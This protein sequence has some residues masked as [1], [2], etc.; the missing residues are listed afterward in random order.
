MTLSH[1]SP[2]NDEVVSSAFSNGIHAMNETLFIPQPFFWYTALMEFNG[3][4]IALLYEDKLVM[5]LRDN[6]PG[7][8]F[9]GMWD[10]PGGGREEDETPIECAVREIQEEFGI[11]LKPEVFIWKKEYPAMH[12]SNQRAYFL[13][14]E[15]TKE[16]IDSIKFGSEGQRWELKDQTFFFD[17]EN[18]VPDLKGRF[19]DYLDSR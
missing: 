6:K 19:R 9:A 4:K 1:F 5:Q 18:V 3:A 11:S 8:R 13:V 16:D 17:N 12:D 2:D 15:I 7:L 14:A 10:F